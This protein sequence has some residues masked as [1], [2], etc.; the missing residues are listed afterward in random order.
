MKRTPLRRKGKSN[1]SQLRNKCDKLLQ[2][3]GKR[4]Y[5]KCE[6]CDNPI[7]CLH[8]FFPK[9]TSSRLRY[10]WGNLIPICN[11]CHMRH[12][13]AGDPSIHAKIILNR[14]QNWYD[15]LDR[16]RHEIIRVNKGYYEEI[17]EELENELL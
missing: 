4:R 9:S 5:R 1:V 13:Q 14:G 10:D 17:L 12:H 15:Q 16:T 6:V 11:G 7:S 3:E 8:H 2:E